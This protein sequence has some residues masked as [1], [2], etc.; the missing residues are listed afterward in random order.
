M[1]AF[2]LLALAIALAM[3]A[4]AVALAAGT[5]ICPLSFRPCF[6][7]SFHF[8]LFQALMPILGWLGGYSLRGFVAAWSHWIAFFLLAGIG[9]HMVVEALK[10]AEEKKQTDPSKGFTMVAL[11]VATSLDALAV[12]LSLAILNVSIW[13]PALAIGLVAALATLFGLF[14]GN[15]AGGTAWGSRFDIGGGIL[16]ICIGVKILLS[17]LFAA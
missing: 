12:G 17:S 2:S 4:F 3:D 5:V 8:G 9:I 16:L 10:P 11:S 14:L 15:R 1:D 6:R 13:I 7:L